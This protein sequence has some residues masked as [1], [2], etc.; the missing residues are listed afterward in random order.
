MKII[1]TREGETYTKITLESKIGTRVEIEIYAEKD[2]IRIN[3][4]FDGKPVVAPRTANEIDIH[5]IE[6]P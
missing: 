3:S 4:G 1:K 6:L 2:V 5:F